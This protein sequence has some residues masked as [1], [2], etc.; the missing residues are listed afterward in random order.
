MLKDVEGQ[1]GSWQKSPQRRGAQSRDTPCLSMN[2][3]PGQTIIYSEKKGVM[4]K[5]YLNTNTPIK[6]VWDRVRNISGKYVCLSKRYLNGKDGVSI[7]DP[8]GI[9]KEHAAAFTG[10]SSATTMQDSRQSRNRMRRSD[11]TWL[12]T[13]MRSKTGWEMSR[14]PSWRPNPVPLDLMGSTTVLIHFPEENSQL[15]PE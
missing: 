5:I 10:N 13:I 7:T 9:A 1:T 14:V 2:S 12:L 11:L 3:G 6:Q 4:D 8:K 15:Y